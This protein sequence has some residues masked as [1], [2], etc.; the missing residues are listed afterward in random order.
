VA[1]LDHEG[2]FTE[3]EE[4]EEGF[5]IAVK[6][7]WAWI[8]INSPHKLS[9]PGGPGFLSSGVRDSCVKL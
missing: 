2:L 8:P 5:F 3:E 9:Y 1:E 4:E 6:S 7:T